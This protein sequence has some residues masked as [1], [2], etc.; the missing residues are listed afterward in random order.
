MRLRHLQLLLEEFK[1]KKV[2]LE[3]NN[4]EI[5]IFHKLDNKTNI[6]VVNKL[7][8]MKENGL[9]KLKRGLILYLAEVQENKEE[10]E[11]VQGNLI[12]RLELC[13]G[14]ELESDSYEGV[15]LSNMEE[16]LNMI[17]KYLNMDS[18]F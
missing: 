17:E 8:C 14:M 4:S 12:Y 11:S 5:N 9:L 15:E 7:S 10:L 2:L 16:L 13:L 3:I 18:T 1:I 6:K